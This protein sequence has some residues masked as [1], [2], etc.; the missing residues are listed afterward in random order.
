MLY[1]IIFYTIFYHIRCGIAPWGQITQ[2]L[3]ISVPKYLCADR[4]NKTRDC[5]NNLGTSGIRVGPSEI[6]CR[7][8]YIFGHFL[9][10]H[11]TFYLFF[12]F[13]F[14]R[15]LFQCILYYTKFTISYH[16]ILEF[17]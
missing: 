5:H 11:N 13:V 6:K 8:T 4:Q 9:V 15:C 14:L 12:V 1:Y 2:V 10:L 17:I 7:A 16:I 3:H